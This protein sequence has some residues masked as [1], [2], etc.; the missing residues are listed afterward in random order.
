MSVRS[1]IVSDA[2][3]SCI[4]ILPDGDILGVDRVREL[5]WGRDIGTQGGAGKNKKRRTHDCWCHQEGIR[6]DDFFSGCAGGLV[7]PI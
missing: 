5:D 6:V 3:Y 4:S 7:L 1:S 2:C